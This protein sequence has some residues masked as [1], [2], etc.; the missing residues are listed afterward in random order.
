MM[1]D[2]TALHLLR[3]A[4][5][6]TSHLSNASAV[7]PFSTNTSVSYNSMQT[8]Q[9]NINQTTGRRKETKQRK[10]TLSNSQEFR[11]TSACATSSPTGKFAQLIAVRS[12]T[13]LQQKMFF[14]PRNR[15]RI[16]R[17]RVCAFARSVLVRVALQN[18]LDG[19]FVLALAI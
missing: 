15:I 6:C 11:F 19:I 10:H 5:S 1:A 18:R 14:Q 12:R 7:Q 17:G 4:T 3:P 8:R 2:A 13:K 9:Q 16:R